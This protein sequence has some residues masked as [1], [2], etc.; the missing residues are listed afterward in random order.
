MET[1]QERM[2]RLHAKVKEKIRHQEMISD[3][4]SKESFEEVSTIMLRIVECW[5]IELS[6]KFHR[7][8]EKQR[9]HM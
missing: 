3:P 9:Y 7:M 8:Y 1:I 4:T 5:P 2:D 6:Q